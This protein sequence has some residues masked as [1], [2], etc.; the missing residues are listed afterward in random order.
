MEAPAVVTPDGLA[1]W[2]ACMFRPTWDEPGEVVTKERERE[3][4]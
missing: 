4:A 1:A 2:C 3:P